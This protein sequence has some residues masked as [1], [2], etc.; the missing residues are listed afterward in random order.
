M[1][2]RIPVAVA[3]GVSMGVWGA[4]PRKTLRRFTE[5]QLLKTAPD[6]ES[7]EPEEVEGKG[8]EGE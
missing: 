5:S 7:G 4:D 1:L 6:Y 2:A 8:D 3:L